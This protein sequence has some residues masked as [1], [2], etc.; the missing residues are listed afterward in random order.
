M[1]EL[2][3]NNARSAQFRVFVQSGG[4]TPDKPYLYVGCLSLG[5]IQQDL[6]T[7]DPIFCP[8]SDVRG[9]YDIVDT[10]DAPPS[11]PTTDFTQHMNRTLNDF[12]WDLRKRKCEFNLAIVG[13][14]C[15]AP[16]NPDDFQ[17]K[18]L[19]RKA[20][21][22]AFNTG[23]FNS[24]GEDAAVDLT[25]TLQ[26]R[27]FDRFRPINF[28]EAADTAV[29]AEALDGLYADDAQCGDC[30]S[31]SDG[32]QRCYVLTSTIAASPSL[33]S[34]VAYS[35][36]GGKTWGYDNVDSLST[37]AGNKI[38]RVG[39]RLVVISL[40]DLA[41]HHKQQSSVD[42]GV[43]GSWTRVSSGYVASKGP[44]A[45][46]S[47]NTSQTYIAGSGGYV[48][49]MSNPVSAVTVLTD[50]SVTS[51]NLND[52]RGSGRTIVAVGASNAV[53]VSNNEGRTWSLVTGPSV[54]VALNTVEVVSPRV[55][56]VGNANGDGYYTIDAGATWTEFTPDSSITNISSIRFVDDMVGYMTVA[57]S[58]S[59]RLYRTGDSGYTWHYDGAY[60]S[61]LPSAARY[62]FVAPCPKNYDT[63]LAGGLK[64]S[65][66]TD[67]IIAVGAA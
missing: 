52:I 49:L 34:Q 42:A 39:T 38:V 32:C 10:T 61:N 12:W 37:T 30:G 13:S 58:S 14:N 20:K 19:V 4:N 16:D 33:A 53:L 28:G 43:S 64:V 6:G 46:W 47:K 31:P 56:F 27:S 17:S 8:S 66:S 21:L 7:G 57:L 44:R 24:L 35:R 63:V 11:L 9:A 54:G 51:Q 48:Y 1:P 22:T 45:I 5:G 60:V 50:G 67:G 2:D 41:H 55:W 3:I 18:I 15:A 59:V 29:F 36:D 65:P 40:T 25:G 62:N 26:M 23:A